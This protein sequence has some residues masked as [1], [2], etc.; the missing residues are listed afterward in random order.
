MSCLNTKKLCDN[1]DCKICYKKSFA[2]IDYSINL[3]DKNINPIN[4]SKY[5]GKKYD[6]ICPNCNHIFNIK[7]SSISVGHRCLYC[8]KSSKVLCDD[9]KCI[10]C[11]NKSFAS[12]NKAELWDYDKNNTIPKKI[13][14]KTNKN[15][16]FKCK[17]CLH[18]FEMSPQSLNNGQNC[19]YCAIPSKLLCK[20]ENCIS[21]FNRSFAS[22]LMANKWSEKNKLKPREIL[23][24]TG[25]KYLFE[26]DKCYH[27]FNSRIADLKGTTNNCQFCSKKILCENENCK[28]CFNNSFASHEKS[29]YWSDKNSIIPRMVFKNSNKKFIFKCNDCDNEFLKVLHSINLCDGWC[30]ICKHKTEKILFEYLDKKYE[31]KNIKSQFV[32]NIDNNKFRYDFLIRNKNILIELDGN[33]HFMQISNWETPEYNLKNDLIKIN[34]AIKNKYTII[35]LLQTDVL[36]NINDWKNKLDNL[37][38]EYNNPQVF[39]INNNINIYKKHID[40]IIENNIIPVII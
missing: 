30:A 39:I 29:K 28:L 16:I 14:N 8:C 18:N 22:H 26:C 20:D 9:D 19:P 31:N 11:F 21:C 38:K 35:H 2:S 12:S 6:F 15:Y 5:S 17:T 34:Y 25:D 37:I 33:Q 10:N 32:I 3:K 23:L 24:K 1:I 36:K 40:K 13:L 27:E 4:I 7:I